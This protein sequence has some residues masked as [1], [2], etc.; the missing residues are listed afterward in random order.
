MNTRAQYI[1]QAAETQA[2]NFL[3][4]QGYTLVQKN[5]RCKVGEIDL[6]MRHEDSLIFVEVRKRQRN[7]FGSELESITPQKQRRIIQASLTYLQATDQMDRVNCQFDVIGIDGN[8][9]I[10]WIPQAFDTTL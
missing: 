7:H 4:Q 2:A 10:T 8:N 3:T 5:F 1:G 6:I 9:Q